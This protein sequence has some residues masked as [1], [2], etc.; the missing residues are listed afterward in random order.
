MKLEYLLPLIVSLATTTLAKNSQENGIGRELLG[1]GCQSDFFSMWKFKPAFTNRI[2]QER[3]LVGTCTYDVGTCPTG[4]CPFNVGSNRKCQKDGYICA[5]R[6]PRAVNCNVFGIFNVSVVTA[7]TCCED[8]GIEVN[9][10]VANSITKVPIPGANLLVNSRSVGTSN[11]QGLLKTSQPS[12]RIKQL[13]IIA[14]DPTKVYLD[15]VNVFDIPNG[16][17]GPIDVEMYMVAR[18]V[19]IIIDAVAGATLSLSSTPGNP[20]AGNA[21]IDILPGSFTTQRGL[22]YQGQVQASVTLLDTSRVD[23]YDILPGRFLAEN[24]NGQ[25]DMAIVSD[26]IIFLN[27]CDINGIPLVVG[28][29]R[30]TV[31][32]GMNIF[33]LNTN[34][35][36]HLVPQSTLKSQLALTDTFFA[37]VNTAHWINIDRIPNAAP[38]YFKA[39][40]FDK[41]TGDEIQTSATTTFK[42]DILAFTKQSQLL[43]IYPSETSSPGNTCY[44]ARCSSLDIAGTDGLQGIFNMTSYESILIG[45]AS[46][47]YQTSLEARPLSE[48]DVPIQPL[49]KAVVLAALPGYSDVIVN[50]ISNVDGPFYTD[51]TTCEESTLAQP[52]FHF[53]KPSLPNYEPFLGTN[54][55]CTARIAFQ[56]GYGFYGYLSTLIDLPT[57]T[58]I[59]IWTSAGSRL[60]HT[61]VSTLQYSRTDNGDI[62]YACLQYHCSHASELITVYLDV[63]VPIIETSATTSNG[64]VLKYPAFACYGECTSPQCIP[65]TGTL[66]TPND[67]SIDGIFQVYAN[68]GG[69]PDFFNT[70]VN[71][72]SPTTLT[73]TFT[74]TF[75][76]Y[77][78]RHSQFLLQ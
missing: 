38:C 55:M 34:G 26:G 10:I 47:P 2:S 58:F 18:A 76:C 11:I 30:F 75:R 62:F 48:Y 61:D 78:Y 74:Y 71:G 53:L 42:P 19:P 1:N 44:E 64:T 43:K 68:A 72:C 77:D 37:Q 29:M 73:D 23:I 63:D 45:S 25:L 31:R 5:Q 17:R 46:L 9:I 57:V 4:K 70:S 51:R 67:L 32:K 66:S 41:T 21:K 65:N 54:E 59:S 36:W 24:N 8:T 60:Y 49:L 14:T 16:F 33:N 39:R 15:A 40:I 6:E 7:C 13:V 27:F 35:Y 52:A 56:D 50:F 20:L 12:S 69:E 3:T 22:P 28:P